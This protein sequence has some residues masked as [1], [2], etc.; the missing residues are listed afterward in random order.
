M[1]VMGGFIIGFD[2]D[3]VDI[4]LRQRNLSIGLRH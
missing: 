1:E 3:P 4:F 2:S